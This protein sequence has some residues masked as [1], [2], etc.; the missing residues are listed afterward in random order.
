LLTQFVENPVKRLGRI[1]AKFS[2]PKEHVEESSERFSSAGSS[3]NASNV[4]STPAIGRGRGL[5]GELR[6]LLRGNKA[7]TYS[8]L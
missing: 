5:L 1:A 7:P 2:A 3:R 4:E 6:S 8:H